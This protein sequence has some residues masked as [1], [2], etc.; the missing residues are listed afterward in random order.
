MVAITGID[1]QPI[2]A[3]PTG[4]GGDARNIAQG[5][6]TY[7]NAVLEILTDHPELRG[8]SVIF[9]NGHGLKEM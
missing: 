3:P 5:G 8:T 9:T 1:V 6:P 4:F 2:G 7:A